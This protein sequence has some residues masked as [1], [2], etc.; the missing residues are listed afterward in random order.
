MGRYEEMLTS[1]V[2]ADKVGEWVKK[3]QNYV[4]VIL[5]SNTLMPT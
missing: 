5:H 4:D 3:G 2:S 1:S